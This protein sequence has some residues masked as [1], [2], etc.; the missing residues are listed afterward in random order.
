MCVWIPTVESMAKLIHK[1]YI[2]ANSITYPLFTL[3]GVHVFS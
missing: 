1:W 3:T 2:W